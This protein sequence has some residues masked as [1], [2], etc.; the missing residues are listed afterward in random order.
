MEIWHS[1]YGI[2]FNAG[3]LLMSI[4]DILGFV[5]VSI[6]VGILAGGV[7]SYVFSKVMS[8][9]VDPHKLKPGRLLHVVYYRNHLVFCILGSVSFG[10][11]LFLTGL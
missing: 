6:M 10:V 4:G 8:C 2:L 5:F 11:A 9:F 1:V 3:T 7:V